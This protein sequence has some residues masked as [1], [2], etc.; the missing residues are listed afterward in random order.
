MKTLLFFAGYTTIWF[1]AG[2]VLQTVAYLAR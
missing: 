1:L 2:I